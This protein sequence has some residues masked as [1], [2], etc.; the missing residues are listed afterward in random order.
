MRSSRCVPTHPRPWQELEARLAPSLSSSAQRTATSSTSP[1]PP[2]DNVRKLLGGGHVQAR[3]ALAFG[4]PGAQPA[5]S[6]SERAGGHSS[7]CYP[8]SNC[9]IWPP[10]LAFP[11]KRV[12]KCV[13][14]C[15]TGEM[16]WWGRTVHIGPSSPVVDLQRVGPAPWP[17]RQRSRSDAWLWITSNFGQLMAV[18]CMARANVSLACLT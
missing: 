2:G 7:L 1:P 15:A 3:S 13:P 6:F 17:P 5:A 11:K 12:W 10:C 8:S 4:A 9:S 16:G 14:P 18:L